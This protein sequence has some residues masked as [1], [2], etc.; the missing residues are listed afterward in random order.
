MVA[1][2]SH[3]LLYEESGKNVTGLG[4]NLCILMKNFILDTMA[5]NPHPDFHLYLHT[6][7]YRKNK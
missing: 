4:E 6:Y 2:P 1:F 3:I 7:D 5:I